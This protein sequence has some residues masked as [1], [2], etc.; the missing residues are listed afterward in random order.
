MAHSR[1][2]ENLETW[3]TVTVP[4][5]GEWPRHR[6]WNNA[7]NLCL[8]RIAIRSKSRYESRRLCGYFV[9]DAMGKGGQT[10][11]DWNQAM[12]SRR[13]IRISDWQAQPRQSRT[14][15][16]VQ[17]RMDALHSVGK[18]GVGQEQPPKALGTLTIFHR[19]ICVDGKR[20]QRA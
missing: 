7:V 20:Q 17:S 14:S 18:S 3:I 4:S 5:L 12:G 13:E 11:A 9:Y 15:V 2:R 6:M 1:P 8:P 10:T 19:E 16:N